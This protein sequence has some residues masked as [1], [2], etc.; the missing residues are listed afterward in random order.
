M[1]QLLLALSLILI[2]WNSRT[3]AAKPANSLALVADDGAVGDPASAFRLFQS[4]TSLTC[5][6]SLGIGVAV[7]LTN[8]AL[9][10]PIYSTA[11][12][13]QL[14]YLLNSAPRSPEGAISQRTDQ[15]QH[16]KLFELTTLNR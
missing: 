3:I 14:S 7:L 16:G 9:H 2:R 6:T 4:N 11:A 10:N 8:W 1:R 12:K 5:F 15:V 13:N